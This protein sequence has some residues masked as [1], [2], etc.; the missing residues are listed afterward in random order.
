[1]PLAVF[2]GP[3]EA[4]TFLARLFQ[5]MADIPGRPATFWL[6]PNG[7]GNYHFSPASNAGLYIE[8]VEPKT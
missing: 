5:S 8:C 1:M 7:S 2:T 4:L 6:L 3:P